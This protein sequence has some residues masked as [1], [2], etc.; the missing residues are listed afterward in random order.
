MGDWLNYML[1]WKRVDVGVVSL[2]WSHV[3]FQEIVLR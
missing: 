3:F 2:S 1:L